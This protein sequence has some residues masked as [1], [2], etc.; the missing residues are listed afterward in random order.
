MTYSE[1]FAAYYSQYRAEAT[2]PVA[3]DDEF[4]IGMRLANE[5]VNRWAN[6]DNTYWKELFT[7]AQTT[8]TGGVVTVT[9]GVKTYAAPTA[10]REAGGFVKI[11]NSS[12][13]TV[14]SYPIL[15]PQDAQFRS[16]TATYAYFT[17]S[18]G[19]GFTLR[20][21]PAPDASVNGLRID[22]VYYKLPTIFAAGTDV[23]EMSQPYFIVHRMLANRFRASRNPY[24]QDAVADAE[25]ILKT[26][27]MD[28][29]SGSW[30]N[31]F[32]VQDR[33]GAQFGSSFGDGG[34]FF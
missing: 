1:I 25:D 30:A 22:Y 9:T 18:P 3:A 6:Y 19:S 33:S 27:Q 23:S 10:F 21:N 28:N 15:D 13:T 17:G 7:T 5:A 31:P 4:I 2:I 24:Y 29:N 26:M 14:R 34:G 20:L 8:S 16:D 12:G 32:S 11:L